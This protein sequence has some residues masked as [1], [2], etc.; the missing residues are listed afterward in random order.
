MSSENINFTIQFEVIG[1]PTISVYIDDKL[2]HNGYTD[3]TFTHDSS[4][5]DHMLKI[6]HSGKTNNTPEQF[7]KISSIMIDGVN[8]R[9]ILYTSSYNIPNYPEPWATHQR[10][11]G[12]ELE[13]RVI[14]QCELSHNCE[15]HLPFTSPFYEFVM[16]HVR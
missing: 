4:F 11:Q 16:D 8:I 13:E 2:V 5:E 9:D 3:C 14:G 1:N 15:W 6:V 10:A 7:A 12:V